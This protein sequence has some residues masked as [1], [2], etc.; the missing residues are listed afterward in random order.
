[1]RKLTTIIGICLIACV[2]HAKTEGN[3]APATTTSKAN[4]GQCQGQYGKAGKNFDSGKILAR[5]QEAL[6]K[7][8][9]EEQQATSNGR[10][11]VAAAIQKII[12]DLNN[13]V[14]ALNGKDKA[15]FKAAN[16]QRKQ[17]REALEALRKADKGA[18]GGRSRHTTH[19]NVKKD[20]SGNR[21]ATPNALDALS[22]R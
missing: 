6:T 8:Q 3:Q 15:A 14:T 17:D 4:Q 18:Q 2:T 19:D 7:R 1:M 10:A 13:M 11:D 16:E 21:Q 9:A 12:N 20:A 5:I 22:D